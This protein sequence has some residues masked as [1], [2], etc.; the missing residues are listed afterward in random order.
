MDFGVSVAAPLWHSG[1]H[2]FLF[3]GDDAEGNN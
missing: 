1:V 2:C 3:F